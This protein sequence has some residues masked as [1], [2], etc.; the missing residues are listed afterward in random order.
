MEQTSRELDTKVSGL[1]QQFLELKKEIKTLEDLNEKLDLIQKTWQSRVRQHNELA[2]SCAAVKEDCLQ[3]ADIITH[4]QQIVL[5]HLSSILTQASEVVATLTDVE[6]PKWKHRQ[7]MACI[8]SPLDTCLD[9]L[10]KW[11][12]TVAEVIVGIREQLQKLQDQ[13][14]KYNCTNAHSLAPTIMK[15]EEFALPL[16]TK[17]LT[18]A[19][20][21][22]TQPVMQNS[23]QRPLILKTGVG[24]RVTLR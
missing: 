5:Q 22:E 7:Q 16:L 20:V 10:Q 11:F 8:G 18:N 17:L 4:T 21:V 15:I 9:H 23:P 13:N 6:L 12:T 3:R 24:F 2:Q 19:L 14:N 1:K